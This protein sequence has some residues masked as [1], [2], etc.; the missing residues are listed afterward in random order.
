VYDRFIAVDA[1]IGAA[2]GIMSGIALAPQGRSI[3]LGEVD[4][5]GHPLFTPGVGSGTVGNIL[6]APVSVKKGVMVPGTPAANGEAGTPAIVGVVGDFD[7]AWYGYTG[8]IEMTVDTSA[9]LV[10]GQEEIHLFRQGMVAVRFD[11]DLSFVVKDTAE[12]VLLTGNV[13]AAV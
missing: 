2:N 7:D 13:L 1:A 8:S 3:V 12:F 5:N 9:T 6:G 4:G 11:W 10:D